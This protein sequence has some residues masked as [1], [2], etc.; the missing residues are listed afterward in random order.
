MKVVNH[1]PNKYKNFYDNHRKILYPYQIIALVQKCLDA[2]GQGVDRVAH[3]YTLT[4]DET[5]IIK[6]E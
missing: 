2:K 5:K 1:I 4:S 6:G 3:L